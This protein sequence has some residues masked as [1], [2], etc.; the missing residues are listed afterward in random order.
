MAGLRGEELHV[1][2]C[3]FLRLEDPSGLLL[4]HWWKFGGL[5]SLVLLFLLLRSC[6]FTFLC[7]WNL[8]LWQWGPDGELSDLC[9][10]CTCWG[11][12]LDRVDQR[13]WEWLVVWVRPLRLWHDLLDVVTQE[14]EVVLDALFA[15]ETVSV[16]DLLSGFSSWPGLFSLFFGSSFFLCLFLLL[17]FTLG[18]LL[19]FCLLSSLL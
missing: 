17:F 14:C 8:I 13:W 6:L 3:A 19:L 2:L 12:L 4:S 11:L 7:L 1:E 16:L 15:Q 10:L 5:L 9:P 18:L